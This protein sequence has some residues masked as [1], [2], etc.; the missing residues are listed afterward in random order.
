MQAPTDFATTEAYYNISFEMNPLTERV[1]MRVVQIDHVA[2]FYRAMAF[3]FP[4]LADDAYY[5]DPAVGHIADYIIFGGT[6]TTSACVSSPDYVILCW[7]PFLCPDACV[8]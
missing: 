5:T 6:N 2:A 8:D 4:D 1:F 3:A 7:C